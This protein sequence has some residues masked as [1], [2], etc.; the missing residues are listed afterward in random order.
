MP[1]L[2]WIGRS[3]EGRR[4]KWEDSRE[5]REE[6]YCFSENNSLCATPGAKDGNHVLDLPKSPMR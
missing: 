3:Q 4:P 5:N 1:V 2:I 6:V